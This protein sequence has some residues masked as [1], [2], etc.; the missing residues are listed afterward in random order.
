M[1]ITVKNT[2]KKFKSDISEHVTEKLSELDSKCYLQRKQ[3]DYKFN[4]HQKENKKLNLPTSDG[5]HCMRAYVYGN[6]MFSES[7]IYLSNKCISNSEALEHDSYGA[8]Y[9]KQYDKF[10]EKMQNM[11]SEY[12][13]QNF[14]E[15]NMITDEEDDMEGIKITD[16]NV[17]EIVDSILDNV[18]PL[19]PEYIKIFSEI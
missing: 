10:I 14:R 7:N 4:I 15:Q 12:E 17:D 5:K 16:E 8:I 3:S 9:K 1:G 11:P 13:K 18:L 6:L 2:I 19:S